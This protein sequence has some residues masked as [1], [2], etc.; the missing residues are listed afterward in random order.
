MTTDAWRIESIPLD[1]HHVTDYADSVIRTFADKHT[2]Q[3][4]LTGKS[5]RLPADVIG[6]AVRRLEYIDLD[7]SDRII[8]K[9]A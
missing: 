1:T 8:V 3:L 4:Y 6:R 2:Q 9:K 5:K 7:Y